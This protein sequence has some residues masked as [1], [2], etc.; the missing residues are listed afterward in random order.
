MHYSGD[1]NARSEQASRAEMET[2][3]FPED[4]DVAIGRLRYYRNPDTGTRSKTW[5]KPLIV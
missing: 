5:L 4:C 2:N 3:I 1:N